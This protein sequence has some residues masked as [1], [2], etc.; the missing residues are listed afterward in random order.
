[1]PTILY[2]IVI[3]DTHIECP[4]DFKRKRMDYQ[5]AKQI[6][7]DE[8]RAC[9]RLDNFLLSQLKNLPKSRIYRMIR[10]GEVRINGKR[11]KPATRLQAGDQVRIPPFRG[12][13][14]T[15]ETLMRHEVDWLESRVL[16]EDADIMV[17]DKPAGLAVHGGSGV[18]AGL[19]EQLR[20]L[21]P[22]AKTL[23]LVHRLDK[24]TSGCILVAKKRSVLRQLH[25]LFVKQAIRKTY[26]AVVQGA[27]PLTLETINQPLRKNVLRSGERTV[28]VDSQG[29]P[30]LTQFCMLAQQPQASVVAVRP[31]TGRTHQIRVHAQWAGHPI[32]GDERYGDA[33]SDKQISELGGMQLCLHAYTL[34]FPLPGSQHDV[35]IRAEIPSHIQQLSQRLGLLYDPDSATFD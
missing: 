14:P 21:R 31:H 32:V 4:P 25:E 7:I 30:A 19:I 15:P 17:I 6:I 18:H 5:A 26:L 23:E 2:N 1:V 33:A 22:R 24:A 13:P 16:Y 11:V 3:R 29:K 35:V 27:W 12:S 8:D 10:G 34:G 9:Q 20:C 28:V